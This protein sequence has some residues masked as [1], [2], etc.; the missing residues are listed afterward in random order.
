MLTDDLSPSTTLA[1]ALS[2]LAKPPRQRLEASSRWWEEGIREEREVQ[3]KEVLSGLRLFLWLPGAR[4]SYTL[5]L[6]EQWEGSQRSPVLEEACF[7]L[8]QR[9]GRELIL[10][11]LS[12]QL[13]PDS[14]ATRLTSHLGKH[15]RKLTKSV[16]ASTCQLVFLA[17]Q[18][19]SW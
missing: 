16:S 14:Q 10:L 6:W 1:L 3:G 19:A 13:L 18:Q 17:C 5:I 11:G 12:G 4:G 7:P 2:W 9:P 15:S 8:R